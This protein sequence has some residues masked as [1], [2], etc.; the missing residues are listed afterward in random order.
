[1]LHRVIARG[2]RQVDIIG[3]LDEFSGVSQVLHLDLLGGLG[4]SLFGELLHDLPGN[5]VKALV[6]IEFRG[7]PVL[8]R[9]RGV[10]HVALRDL[11]VHRI[12]LLRAILHLVRG[13]KEKRLHPH[14]I[15]E[16]NTF[17]P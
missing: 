10:P 11:N 8:A 5:D 3:R 7:L 17:I 6:P 13:E 16:A 14:S 9:P 15:T 12:V 2:Q 4:V 1:M